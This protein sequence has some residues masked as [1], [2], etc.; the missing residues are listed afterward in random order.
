LEEWVE[1][2]DSQK[3]ES[4]YEE[5]PEGEGDRTHIGWSI[6]PRKRVVAK[7]VLDQLAQVTRHS[8]RIARVGIPNSEK[9][10]M[11][12]QQLNNISG[13]SFGVVNSVDN[14]YFKEVARDVGVSL[15]NDEKQV[16]Q[17]LDMFRAQELAQMALD[18][19][20]KE[21]KK[22]RGE[23]ENLQ[24]Q[25]EEDKEDIQEKV[26]KKRLKGSRERPPT[27]QAKNANGGQGGGNVGGGI[28]NKRGRKKK[29]EEVSK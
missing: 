9:A 4:E 8:F 3:G 24:K 21:H 16:D 28:G 20:D 18:R 14:L 25:V 19:L 10:T 17:Q 5:G 13:N 23:E 1:E 15:G 6:Q 29:M 27:R 11:G 7:K 12:V 26:A 2:E 22:L